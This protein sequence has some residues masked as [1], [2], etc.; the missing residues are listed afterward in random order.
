M[1]G[2]TQKSLVRRIRWSTWL[3]VVLA[4]GV[5]AVVEIPGRRTGPTTYAHG[6]PWAYLERDYDLDH[7]FSFSSSSYNLAQTPSSVGDVNRRRDLETE[8]EAEQRKVAERNELWTNI[9]ASLATEDEMNP[10]G[11]TNIARRRF[12]SALPDIL[13]SIF[14]VAAVAWAW[15]R[16]RLRRRFRLQFRLRTL[17]IAVPLVGLACG[18]F[19]AWRGELRAE[20]QL[21]NELAGN[22]PQDMFTGQQ[23]FDTAVQTWQAPP[24]LSESLAKILAPRE[25]FN[26]ITTLKLF[27]D[28]AIDSNISRL[29]TF[30]CLNQLR[31]V[32]SKC[33]TPGLKPISHL[34][35]LTVL[36]LPDADVSDTTLA[37]IAKLKNLTALSIDCAH[38]TTQ[39][40]K[41]LVNL[42]RLKYLR[43]VSISDERVI[44]G[45][46]ELPMLE[47]LVI[48]TARVRHLTI[49]G[50]PRL[51]Q[52]GTEGNSL[53]ENNQFSNSCE[54]DSLSLNS[55]PAL[56]SMRLADLECHELRLDGV[57]ELREVEFDNGWISTVVFQTPL[58]LPTLKSFAVSDTEIDDASQ[59]SFDSLDRLRR[60]LIA[61]VVWHSR[62]PIS[63]RADNLP[64]LEVLKV[65][66]NSSLRSAQFG[67]L[68]QLKSFSFSVNPLVRSIDVH[69]MPR[70]ASLEVMHMA[71]D[72]DRDSMTGKVPRAHRLTIAGL[73][74]LKQ[75]R[76]L[77]LQWVLLDAKKTDDIAHLS[78][79]E[80]LDLSWTNLGDGGF[81]RVASLPCLSDVHL[82]A[83]DL[84]DDAI[85]AAERLPHGAQLELD[86]NPIDQTAVDQLKKSRPDLQVSSSDRQDSL[87]AFHKQIAAHSHEIR[88]DRS[89]GLL[90]DKDLPDLV[91]AANWLRS[92]NLDETHLTDAGIAALVRVSLLE[93]LSVRNTHISDEGLAQLRDL[94]NLREL[95]LS[96]NAI[97]GDGLRYLHGLQNLTTLDLS[98]TDVSDA[99][100]ANLKFV[101]H[102]ERL[103]LAHTRIGDAGLARLKSLPRLRVLNLQSTGITDAGLVQL[104]SLK[105][106]ESLRLDTYVINGNGLDH[107]RLLPR[108][109]LLELI[110]ST[111]T[112]LESSRD[113]AP[114][115]LDHVVK[116]PHLQV[117]L[118]G[119]FDIDDR[120]MALLARMPNLTD[121][122]SNLEKS[123]QVDKALP[124]VRLWGSPAQWPKDRDPFLLFDTTGE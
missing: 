38:V 101:P 115:C 14:L 124:K 93:S 20:T 77:K 43:L 21:H 23:H 66:G 50:L 117:L 25:A 47:A 85:V 90:G 36:E 100:L 72:E 27:G 57:P 84:D 71:A 118:V 3:V 52:F 89:Q 76:S 120:Q 102:L 22:G 61:N 109:T 58:A 5:M 26:R 64:N 121:L 56:R 111:T 112:A 82:F 123:P 79:L 69:G 70:L 105:S 98:Q 55:L 73:S 96:A 107:L 2:D 42:P 86:Q 48:E 40:L 92:L 7:N 67:R 45:L 80:G 75:I 11:F 54:I 34:Q 33:T 99:S 32:N 65:Q 104:S 106:L 49:R 1:T 97:T 44:D 13:I 116:L 39:G 8:G 68:P 4:A 95:N 17:L 119:N 88:F 19:V 83:A 41:Q 113:V 6:W 78:T 46:S 16:W 103:S 59:L 60:L 108:L 35:S 31:V 114:D 15:Q 30:R 10:W 24:W 94:P 53:A 63:I 74:E 91:P 18:R 9:G 62:H 87:V 81:I 122:S 28:Q 37:G 12:G 51:V 29:P 110:D